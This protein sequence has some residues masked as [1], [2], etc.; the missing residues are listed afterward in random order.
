MPKKFIKTIN[1]I[2]NELW[3]KTSDDRETTAEEIKNTIKQVAGYTVVN[4]Y[5]EELHNLD[6][7]EQVPDT[8]TW[9]VKKPKQHKV[10]PTEEKKRKQIELPK[11]VVEEAEAY[12]VN[13]S[14]VVTEAILNEISS[15]QQFIEDYLNES[16]TD[17]EQQYML[18]LMKKDIYKNIGDRQ[19]MAQLDRQRR[20]LYKTVFDVDTVDNDHISELRSKTAKIEDLV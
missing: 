20:N 4:K 16:I 14:K 8:Q 18:E 1:E 13:F 17:K 12:G 5:W 11:T 3:E 10:K 15:T 7:V 19:R 9:L 6:R 2:H